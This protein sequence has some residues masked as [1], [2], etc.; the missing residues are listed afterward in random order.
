ME[1][2]HG[3]TT[4]FLSVLIL[5]LG[6]VATCAV[7]THAACSSHNSCNR[8]GDGNCVVDTRLKCPP[9]GCDTSKED[10][11]TCKCILDGTICQ[12]K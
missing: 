11:T 12:C 10:C 3:T 7:W 1:R 8:V 4:G 9:G 6:I 5:A 2:I